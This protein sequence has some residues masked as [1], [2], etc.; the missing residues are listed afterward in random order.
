MRAL[1]L[2]RVHAKNVIS[3]QMAL[4]LIISSRIFYSFKPITHQYIRYQKLVL[5]QRGNHLDHL[6]HLSPHD[7]S[8]HLCTFISYNGV[9]HCIEDVPVFL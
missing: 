2:V 3:V 1:S 9:P 5:P 6:N 7:G 8:G 4:V